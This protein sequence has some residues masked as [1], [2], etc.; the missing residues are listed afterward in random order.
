MVFKK[1]LTPLNKGGAIHKHAGKGATEQTLPS[2]HALN[3]LTTGS[4]ASRTMN[5]YA[6]AT[7]MA[8]PMP[9]DNMAGSPF[10]QDSM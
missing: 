4:P 3:T 8:Q 5:D 2:R 9:D 6:K 10:D 7:P 1:H